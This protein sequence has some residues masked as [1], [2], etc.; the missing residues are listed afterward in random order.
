MRRTKEQTVVEEVIDDIICN[1]CGE[2]LKTPDGYG[3]EGLI[4]AVVVG[5]YGSRH[6]G[7]MNEYRFDVCERCLVSWFDTFNIQ[8]E[9]GLVDIVP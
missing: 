9:N 3:F 7:D 4:G 8:P 2:S 6:L 1:K 5:G